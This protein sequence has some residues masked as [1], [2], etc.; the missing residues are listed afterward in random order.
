[1][2]DSEKNIKPEFLEGSD[3]PEADN[4]V[5]NEPAQAPDSNNT[6]GQAQFITSSGHHHRHHHHSSKSRKKRKRKKAVKRALI[7]T[8]IVL[9]AVAVA[10]VSTIAVLYNT[11]KNEMTSDNFDIKMPEKVEEVESADNGRFIYYNK[12]KYRFKEDMINMLF[13]GVDENNGY[14]TDGIGGNGQSDLLALVAIDSG[15][16]TVNIINIPRDIMTDV[17]VYSP[18]GGYSGTEKMQIAV[19]YAFGDGEDTSCINSI[20]AVRT[21]FYNIPINSYFALRMEGVPDVNDSIGGV[22]V[23]SP[24]TISIFEKGETYH[25]EGE[26]ALMFVRTR[27]MY[28]A[29]AN[30]K[31]NQRQKAYLSSFI[32]KFVSLTKNNVGVPMSVYNASA[33]YSYTNLNPNRIAYLATEFIVNKNMK[34]KMQSVPVTVKQNENHAENYVKEEEFYK[35]FLNTFYEKVSK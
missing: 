3:T 26:E 28:E 8:G 19:A 35:I 34:I 9:L 20:S 21:L 15:N 14:E 7:I 6:S 18:S 22:D 16:S 33:P 5:G 11:G 13:L 4:T 23:K 1:M 25:L 17:K 24:E 32:N 27:S 29:S 31:R 10:V 12:E 30:L 2:S